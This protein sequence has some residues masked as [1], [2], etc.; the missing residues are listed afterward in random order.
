METLSVKTSERNE[1]QDITAKVQAVVKKSGVKNGVAHVFS[2]HTTAGITI[3]ENA[4]PSVKRDILAG[5]ARL[6][7]EDGDYRHMEGN[8]DAHIKASMMGFSLTVMVAG[9]TLVLGTW[10]DIYFAEFDGPRSRKVQVS[11]SGG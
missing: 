2:P 3:N 10:Q 8:S 1:L 5:L 9:G 11:V 4:D 7:P 6:V